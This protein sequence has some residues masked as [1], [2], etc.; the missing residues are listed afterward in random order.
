MDIKKE[1]ELRVLRHFANNEEGLIP[2]GMEEYECIAACERLEEKK[3]VWVAWIEGHDFEALRILPS[4][5][6][7][8]KELEMEE[9]SLR[10]KKR[11]EEVLETW[12]NGGTVVFGKE[13]TGF[14]KLKEDWNKGK[15]KLVLMR[16]EEKGII[17]AKGNVYDW[18]IDQEKG[19]SYRL[20]VYFVY[21]ASK[22]LEWMEGNNKER[23][24]WR[25]FNPMFPN[26]SGN[27]S[28]R[29]QDLR[30]IK[31][32]EYPSFAQKIDEVLNW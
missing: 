18:K 1:A 26:V 3:Y 6:V 4:G 9:E 5:L 12:R 27:Q 19:Y 13:P 17:T 28:S 22:K 2:K 23:V 10:V 31:K 7:Y 20:Y 21:H 14:E 8:L 15:A 30:A 32:G 16:L 29:N 11:Y 25:I 24:P